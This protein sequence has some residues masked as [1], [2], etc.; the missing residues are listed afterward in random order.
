V[1]VLLRVYAKCISGQEEAAKKRIVAALGS[2]D[3]AA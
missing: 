3:P 2:I 1:A